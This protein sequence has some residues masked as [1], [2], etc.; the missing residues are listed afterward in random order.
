MRIVA[1]KF[2][3]RRLT[4][5][6]SKVRPTLDRVKGAVFSIFRDR[7]V[8]ASFLDLC[9]G[10]GN[11][12][13][14]ALSRGAKSVIF[15]DRDYHCIRVIASNLEQCGL[16]RTHPQAQ[17]IN[18]DARKGLVYLGRRKAQFDLIY[19]DPPYDSD[20]HEAC[21][22]LIAQNRLLSQSGLI[23]VEHRRVQGLDLPMPLT[24]GGLMLNRQEQYG[25]TVLSFYR[26]EESE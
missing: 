10:T 7:V 24:M 13:I 12:G 21:L 4:I 9:A 17:L 1:G 2:K 15:I 18:L 16:H 3:G 6:G 14:E 23:V 25:D 5:K 11:I 8:D 20:I 19:F 22:E 26:W